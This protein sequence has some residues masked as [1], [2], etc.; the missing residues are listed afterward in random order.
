M[1]YVLQIEDNGLQGMTFFKDEHHTRW[2][3]DADFENVV[4]PD[5]VISSF[6]DTNVNVVGDKQNVS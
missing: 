3:L 4:I 2:V 6:S 1:Y 5:G